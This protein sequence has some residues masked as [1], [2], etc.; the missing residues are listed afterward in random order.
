[1][2]Y[3]HFSSVENFYYFVILIKKQNLNSQHGL[4]LYS[5][6]RFI[7]IYRL[8]VNEQSYRNSSYDCLL[9]LMIVLG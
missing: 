9:I 5:F 3:F 7:Y 2:E 1:M 4:A 8:Q 6:L